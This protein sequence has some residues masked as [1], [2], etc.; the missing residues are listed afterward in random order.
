MKYTPLNLLLATKKTLIHKTHYDHREKAIPQWFSEYNSVIRLFP[1]TNHFV[2][3]IFRLKHE[4]ILEKY[5]N[6]EISNTN[7]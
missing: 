5:F 3:K 6:V 4:I 7:T 2:D 1:E